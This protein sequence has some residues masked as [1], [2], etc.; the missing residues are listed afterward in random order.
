MQTM[1][2]R[3]AV[4]IGAVMLAAVLAGCQFSGFNDADAKASAGNG[5]T[6]LKSRQLPDGSF[7]VAG[8][9]GFETPDAVL[10]IAEA[11][12]LQ[13]GWSVDQARAAAQAT[14]TNGNS[15]LNA[16]DD[17]ADSGLGAGQAAKVAVLVAR[18]LGFSATAFDPDGDGAVNLRAIIDAAHQPTGSYGALNATLYAAIAKATLGGVPADTLAHIRAAQEAGGGW[19]FAGDPTGA[20]AAADVDTT[21]LAIQALASAAVAGNDADLRQGLTYLANQHRPTGAWQSFGTDDPNST[22]VAMVAITAAGFDPTR[23]CWRDVAV[24]AL[25]GTPYTSPVTWMRADQLPSGQFASPNDAFGVNT[26]ATSQSIQ[27]LRRGWVPADN[28][29]TQPCPAG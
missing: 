11:A 25:S 19:N 28:L 22:A 6:W 1:I 15:A 13:L 23:P 17:Y 16:I 2:K 27:G 4:P 18:P 21:A 26:F 8:F 10:A 24:P 29:A 3:L 20:A 14:Q 7:E 9:P 12:Q 5:T